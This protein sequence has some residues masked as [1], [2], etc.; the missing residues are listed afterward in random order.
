MNLKTRFGVLDEFVKD[1]FIVSAP[2]SALAVAFNVDSKVVSFMIVAFV[3]WILY[4]YKFRALVKFQGKKEYA[5]I[6]RARGYTYIFGF[7]IAFILNGI[8]IF[9]KSIVT[10]VIIVPTAGILLSLIESTIPNQ[11]FKEEVKLFTADQRKNLSKV[12]HYAGSVTIYYSIMVATLTLLLVQCLE[13]QG[14]EKSILIIGLILVS[15]P[16]VIVI[17]YREHQSRGSMDKLVESLERTKLLQKY[18][19]QRNKKLRTKP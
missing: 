8:L 9:Y 7:F 3:F 13:M 2:I 17:Y 14:L 12:L 1:L 16:F 15:I 11:F 6:E 4:I 10:Y 19:V 18:S 5:L